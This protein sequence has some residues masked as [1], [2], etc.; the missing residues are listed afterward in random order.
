MDNDAT[1]D[2]DAMALFEESVMAIIVKHAAAATSRCSEVDAPWC[3]CNLLLVPHRASAHAAAAEGQGE[4]WWIVEMSLSRCDKAFR[5]EKEAKEFQIS[6][7]GMV[8][9]DKPPIQVAALAAPVAQPHPQLCEG[10][11]GLWRHNKGCPAAPAS[12]ERCGECGHKIALNRF[13][14][15]TANMAAPHLYKPCGH[16]CR[17]SAGEVDKA[18]DKDSIEEA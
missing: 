10:C 8:A 11:G 15:C 3:D 1:P 17:E 12:A 7:D 4:R 6:L 13:G 18:I 16:R 14:Y 5:T 2:D 9:L